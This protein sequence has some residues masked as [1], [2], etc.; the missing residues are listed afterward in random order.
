[1]TKFDILTVLGAVF[2]HFCPNK[3]KICQISRLSGQRVPP[4]GRKPY[5]W[6]TE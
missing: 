2:P 3:R 1:M 5:F 6:T 4:A